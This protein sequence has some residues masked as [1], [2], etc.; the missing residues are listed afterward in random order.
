M[1]LHRQHQL[2]PRSNTRSV[3]I[4]LDAPTHATRY[5][6]LP[7]TTIRVQITT[8]HT[9]LYRTQTPVEVV[10]STPTD[11][12][13]DS[14]VPTANR[15]STRDKS[16]QFFLLIL[17]VDLPYL[18]EQRKSVQK[19]WQVN[20]ACTTLA[21]PLSDLHT[22]LVSN[23]GTNLVRCRIAALC[24][25]LDLSRICLP[26]KVKQSNPITSPYGSRRL[27]LPHF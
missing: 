17:L 15:H 5:F 27:R 12:T 4:I 6:P 25:L 9:C 18:S 11:G 10:T 16:K 20:A 13:A 22:A 1:R 2:R 19:R 26:S 3:V 23:D 24:I 8:D 14:A 7:P 21:T